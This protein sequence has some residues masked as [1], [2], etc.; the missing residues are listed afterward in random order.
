MTHIIGAGGGGKG[1]GGSQHVPV[2]SPNTLKSVQ[3]ASIIDLIGEGQIVGLVNGAKSIYLDGV[4]LQASDGTYNFSG[5][6]YDLRVG[7]QT[8]EPLAAALSGTKNTKVNPASYSKVEYGEAKAQEVAIYDNRVRSIVLTIGIPALSYQ[9]P[10]NGDLV[11]NSTSLR[12]DVK[13][14]NGSYVTYASETITGKCTALYQKSYRVSLSKFSA[15]DYPIYI[16][17]VS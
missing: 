16:R 1:G 5:F 17:V 9:N 3:Y 10:S 15:S 2:E 14:S 13:S 11:G 6:G 8:Q 4:P 12:I 7:T